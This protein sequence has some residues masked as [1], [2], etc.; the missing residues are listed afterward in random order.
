MLFFTIFYIMNISPLNQEQQN[1][2]SR[3]KHIALNSNVL[4]D[5]SKMGA[6]KT[7]HALLLAKELR[8]KLIIICPANLRQK[9]SSVTK[10]FQHEVRCIEV[11]SY[12]TLRG[13]KHRLSNNDML[14][15]QI[16]KESQLSHLYLHRIDVYDIDEESNG[17]RTVINHSVKFAPSNC[18]TEARNILVVIDEMQAIKNDSSTTKA[19]HTLLQPVISTQVQNSKVLLMSGSPVDKK[20]HILRL[21]HTLNFIES[22]NP[23]KVGDLKHTYLNNFEKFETFCSQSNNEKYHS[24]KIQHLIQHVFTHERVCD[25]K[26]KNNLNN[27]INDYIYDLVINIFIPCLSSNCEVKHQQH[28]INLTNGFFKIPLSKRESITNAVGQISKVTSGTNYVKRK[29][30]HKSI[31]ALMLQE[32]ETQKICTFTRII[33]DTLKN[34][35]NIKI[36]AG[37][38]FKNTIRTLQDKLQS[39]GIS[40]IVIDGSIHLKDRPFL[41]KKF[42]EPNNEY[43]VL[44]GNLKSISTGIDLDDQH[45]QFPRLAI[46]S[47][48]Y[49]TI[50]Q[51]Q[52]AGRIMRASTQSNATMIAVYSNLDLNYSGIPD[53]D[54]YEEMKLPCKATDF[55]KYSS[56]KNVDK[57]TD[58]ETHVLI[59]LSN[60]SSIIID[61][62]GF[63][64]S[65]MLPGKAPTWIE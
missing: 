65:D 60:K 61:T 1:H 43:R 20:E 3:L 8:L 5:L 7:Y 62:T 35:T 22:P 21:L 40:V 31:I 37:V 46:I 15:K 49:D 14:E 55:I 48:N 26:E 6:G 45:G 44:L 17:K 23:I 16:K 52:F 58:K 9:W 42:Q 54:M 13:T 34:D 27:I 12:E 53:N 18:W 63:S 38:S 36:I 4:L 19:V 32:I 11:L 57:N 41:V 24:I 29:G 39:Q 10:S 2:I 47:P 30:E 59:S 64:S 50:T 33:K 28:K 56:E 25:S 51:Y